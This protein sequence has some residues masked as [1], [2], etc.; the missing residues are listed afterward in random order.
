MSSVYPSLEQANEVLDYYENYLLKCPHII[1]I[2]VVAKNQGYGLDIGI[3][4]KHKDKVK[5]RDIDEFKVYFGLFSSDEIPEYFPV[6]SEFKYKLRNFLNFNMNTFGQFFDRINFD[7][8]PQTFDTKDLKSLEQNILN[9]FNTGSS[10]LKVERDIIFTQARIDKQ[11]RST[12]STTRRSF[13]ILNKKG[14]KATLG[15]VFTLL[16]FPNDFFGITNQHLFDYDGAKL[17][18]PVYDRGKK[19]QIGSL[20]WVADDRYREVAFIKMCPTIDNSYF[21]TNGTFLIEQPQIGMKVTHNGFATFPDNFCNQY[22]SE[23]LSCN[24]TIR[25]ID[26]NVP[27]KW[28]IYKNQLLID[29]NTTYGDSG[30]I[31]ITENDLKQRK[32]VGLNF[33]VTI[34][35][36][37]YNTEKDKN[38]IKSFSIANNINQIFNIDFKIKQEIFVKNIDGFTQTSLLNTFKLNNNSF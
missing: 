8:T 35:R 32:I 5:L 30:S 3:N 15:G 10:T 22:K 33:G 21:E 25:H 13:S 6:P 27:E 38:E 4:Y 14:T 34:E 18:D 2:A 1:Y 29:H 16:E 37:V 26:E 28:K 7:I 20:F 36:V 11:H 23:I 31:V 9:S 12:K 24:T 19:T 17:G